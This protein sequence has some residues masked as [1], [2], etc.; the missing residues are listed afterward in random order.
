[1][2]QGDEGEK[3]A[4][5]A[6][7]YGCI[8]TCFAWLTHTTPSLLTDG[9]WLHCSYTVV[10]MA[11]LLMNQRS[12]KVEAALICFTGLELLTEPRESELFWNISHTLLWLNSHGHVGDRIKLDKAL[13]NSLKFSAG[14]FKPEGL[15]GRFTDTSISLKFKVYVTDMQQMQLLTNQLCTN[16]VVHWIKRFWV[17][18]HTLPNWIGGV[19]LILLFPIIQYSANSRC[20][21]NTEYLANWG[22]HAM[23]WSQ[24]HIFLMCFNLHWLIWHRMWIWLCLQLENKSSFEK[25]SPSLAGRCCLKKNLSVMSHIIKQ[26]SNQLAENVGLL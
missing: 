20:S 25:S 21:Q 5:N 6:T 19:C 7:P 17:S 14:G 9:Q 12:D 24:L 8:S 15:A 10:N 22:K 4:A 23:L 13:G 16:V 26:I 1:M 11:Y 18:R 2:P 3:Q